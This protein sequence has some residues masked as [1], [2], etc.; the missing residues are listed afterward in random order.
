VIMVA[1]LQVGE[2]DVMRTP[3]YRSGRMTGADRDTGVLPRRVDEIRALS[4]SDS[5]QKSLPG[6]YN[7]AGCSAA[8]STNH[9]AGRSGDR[10]S[11]EGSCAAANDRP[12][13]GTHGWRRTAA[14]KH[15]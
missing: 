2:T 10:G 9:G 15:Q 3:R 6:A 4:T 14:R 8:Q 11:R 13:C 5:R 1:E 12:A 7:R